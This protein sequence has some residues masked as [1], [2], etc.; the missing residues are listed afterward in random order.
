MKNETT[1][2][3]INAGTIEIQEKLTISQGRKL[4]AAAL[5]L[6]C[7]K[8]KDDRKD[9]LEWMK[10]FAGSEAKWFDHVQVALGQISRIMSKTTHHA[11]S[12]E[13]LEWGGFLGGWSYTDQEPAQK[14]LNQFLN[15]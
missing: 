1:P 10:D 5:D 11:P 13:T 6:L 14:W 3:S 15:K 9:L 7:S 2:L 12:P 4:Y 8:N